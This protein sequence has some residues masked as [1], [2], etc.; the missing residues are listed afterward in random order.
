MAGNEP[1]LT[2]TLRPSQRRAKRQVPAPIQNLL[3]DPRR[4]LIAIVGAAA[5]VG[6][7]AGAGIVAAATPAAT[8]TQEYERLEARLA[9][10]V[11]AKDQDIDEQREQISD[12]RV[13]KGKLE[14]AASDVENQQVAADARDAELAARETAV[15]AAE[16]AKKASEFGN[17]VH[18]VGTNV[19]AGTYSIA[20]STDCYYAWMS[21]TGSNADIIDNNIVSGPATVTLRDGDVFETSRCGIWSKIK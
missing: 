3:G 16:T 18:I 15:S 13:E 5:I 7:L 17:G 9:D 19:T 2:G 11:E 4:R 14:A 6:G 10:T 8:E 1:R 12:L 21:G 20:S